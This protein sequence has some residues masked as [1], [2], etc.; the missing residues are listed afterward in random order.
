L[1]LPTPERHRA[2][3]ADEYSLDFLDI[4]DSRYWITDR[5]LS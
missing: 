4:V 2:K 3:V 5:R 1:L